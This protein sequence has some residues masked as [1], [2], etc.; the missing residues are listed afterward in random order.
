V[1]A[2]HALVPAAD[3]VVH[4]QLHAG[5]QHRGDGAA[6]VGGHGHAQAEGV[7]TGVRAVDVAFQADVRGDERNGRVVD[8]AQHEVARDRIA[9]HLHQRYVREAVRGQVEQVDVEDVDAAAHDA[10]VDVEQV[11]D[12]VQAA[13]IDCDV[14]VAAEVADDGQHVVRH[15]VLEVDQTFV[16]EPQRIARGHRR[17]R[18]QERGAHRQG[19]RRAAFHVDDV[20]TG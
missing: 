13:D 3:D 10:A 12:L 7:G 2:L 18:C 15:A 8:V 5:R 4:Q 6:F 1:H 9:G 19:G 16:V 20:V 17:W 11:P 14:A